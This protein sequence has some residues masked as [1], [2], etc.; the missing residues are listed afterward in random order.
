MYCRTWR[1]GAAGTSLGL[2]W[3]GAK[4]AARDLVLVPVA[5]V[6][7]VAVAIVHVVHVV[8]VWHS[9]VSAIWA[10]LVL[11]G[12]VWLVL[13]VFA[14]VPV[15]FVLAVQ[16]AVVHVVDVIIVWDSNVTAVWA[17]LVGV[18]FVNCVSH[19]LTSLPPRFQYIFIKHHCRWIFNKRTLMKM[20]PFTA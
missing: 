16:V 1:P 18:L 12:F 6:E 4:A 2:K 15:A 8:I 11:V 19:F 9:D 17:V 20:T 13:L 10:V 5:I 14:L 3:P 7:G